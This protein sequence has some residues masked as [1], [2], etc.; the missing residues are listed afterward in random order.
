MFERE[1]RPQPFP[2]MSSCIVVPALDAEATLPGVIEELRA[3]LGSELPLIVV[4]DGSTDGTA[5]RARAA[6]AIVISHGVNRGKGA[7]IKSGLEEARRLGRDVA[8]TVDADGQH[9]GASARAVLD[10]SPDPSA[11]VLGVRDLARANAPGANQ[12]SNGVS[13]WWLSRFAGRA[14]G[15]TQCGLRRYP[16]ARTLQLAARARGYAFEA[17][18]LLRAVAASVPI[19]ECSIDV[20]YPPPGERV[21][22]FHV[23]RDPARI[24][25]TVVRTVIELRVARARP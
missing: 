17:E 21:T 5:A 20:R 18:V 10:A 1:A 3:A 25:G 7:A 19:V 13:N 14:F 4:D 24:V 9:P 2:A 16:V 23:V 15:D 8:L 6:G 22:H 11:L 12:W